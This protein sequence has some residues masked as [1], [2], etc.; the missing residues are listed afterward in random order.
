MFCCCFVLHLCADRMTSCRNGRRMQTILEFCGILYFVSLSSTFGEDYVIR[1]LFD[2][3]CFFVRCHCC[4][5]WI[6]WYTY[7]TLTRFPSFSPEFR[8]FWNRCRIHHDTFVRGD[9]VRMPCSGEMRTQKL[10]SHLLKT[11]SS[12]VLPLKPGAGQYIAMHATPTARD[13]FLANSSPSGSLIHLR[14][15][16]TPVQVWS[17]RMIWVILLVWCRSPSS[18]PAEY[19]QVPKHVLLCIIAEIYLWSIQWLRRSSS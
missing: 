12:N 5:C 15:F 17:R 1:L 3:L 6:A 11:P 8:Y 19:K 18:V 10:R 4:F 7:T 13:F 16:Q 9:P 2:R 14:F